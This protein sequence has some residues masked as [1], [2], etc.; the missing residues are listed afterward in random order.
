[1]AKIRS[2]REQYRSLMNGE[3]DAPMVDIDIIVKNEEDVAEA[4]ELTREGEEI[5][6][7]IQASED[8][9]AQ[10]EADIEEAEMLVKMLRQ[11]GLHP[12]VLK[13]IRARPLYRD[14]WNIPMPGAESLDVTGRND[15]QARQLADA[16]QARVEGFR[17]TMSNWGAAIKKRIDQF[18]NWIKS[19]F[20]SKKKSI[21]KIHT[22]LKG[23]K[24]TSIDT[25][26]ANE[27]K[28]SILTLS[29]VKDIHAAASKIVRFDPTNTNA[30]DLKELESTV[31]KFSLLKPEETTVSKILTEF[32]NDEYY[33]S[34]SE[35]VSIS[36]KIDAVLKAMFRV[37]DSLSKLAMAQEQTKS[38]EIK[39]EKDKV[40]KLLK[41]LTRMSKYCVMV[42]NSYI[43]GG[44]AVV[45]CK[46]KD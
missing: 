27:K 37:V 40:Q 39:E 32:L 42:A 30:T 14:I 29:D 20:P 24:K 23:T 34:A 8:A 31:E 10:A 38:D 22:A 4:E 44:G 43:K 41:S 26:K 21:E 35:L 33:N 9:E 28:V 15:V 16:I 3:D 6:A 17:E 5:E 45:S 36:G 18:W 46:K 7:D 19:L 2:A 25:E 1:M 11:D 13:I 12:S